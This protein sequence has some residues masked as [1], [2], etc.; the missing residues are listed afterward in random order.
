[1]NPSQVLQYYG[2]IATRSAALVG[3]SINY[4]NEANPVA[5]RMRS[6]KHHLESML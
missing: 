1:M 5:I 4:S 3:F 2:V 6:S